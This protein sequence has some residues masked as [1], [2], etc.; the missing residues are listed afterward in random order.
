MDMREKLIEEIIPDNF[1]VKIFGLEIPLS[2]TVI[3]MWII[4]AIM[5]TFAIVITRKFRPVPKGR[6]LLA[7]VI[8]SFINSF[9]KNI[10]GHHWK[11][12]APFIGTLAMFL[13]FSNTISI[14]NI[15]PSGEQLYELTHIEFFKHLHY[16]GLKPPT[17]DINV[18]VALA[19]MSMASVIIGTI[20][21]KKVSGWLKSFAEPMPA[22]IPFKI[23]DYLIRPTSLS[24]RLFGNI[25][26]AFIVMEL[27]YMA[28]P[29]ILPAALSV[30][31]D[32]FDGALQAYVFVFLTSFYIAES[33]E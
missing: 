1:T 31:F 3:V 23:L 33:V 21:V 27:V 24:L 22:V 16:H 4:M 14:I 6:Q 7:E 13:V 30:Y 8:V 18:P 26:G 32:L 19:V 17:R 28:L 25:L 11:V 2:D 29:A 12:F 5:I 15:F 10:I 9:T 20:K